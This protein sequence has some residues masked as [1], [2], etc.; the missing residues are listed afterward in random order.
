MP[1]ND[2]PLLSQSLDLLVGAPCCDGKALRDARDNIRRDLDGAARVHL[3]VVQDAS[4]EGAAPLGSGVFSGLASLAGGVGVGVGVGVGGVIIVVVVIVVVVVA[5]SASAS[6]AADH[7]IGDYSD[8][9]N[10]DNEN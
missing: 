8:D 3:E 7:H 1:I 2:E 4:L 9:D 6:T 5:A 10:D